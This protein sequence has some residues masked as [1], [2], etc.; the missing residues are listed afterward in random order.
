M[1]AAISSGRPMRPRGWAVSRRLLAGQ[2]I[3]TEQRRIGRPGRYGVDQDIRRELARQRPC[4][5]EMR[6]LLAT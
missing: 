3:E 5:P 2:A 1:P 4:E 6:S